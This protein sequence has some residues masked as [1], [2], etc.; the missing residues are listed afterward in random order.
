MEED[1][2]A[3]L[4][5]SL[6]YALLGA[7]PGDTPEVTKRKQDLLRDGLQA[8]ADWGFGGV[9]VRKTAKTNV[10][11]AVEK[12]WDKG[13][14][15]RERYDNPRSAK[16]REKKEQVLPMLYKVLY[17]TIEYSYMPQNVALNMAIGRAL[18][19]A[20]REGLQQDDPHLAKLYAVLRSV[21]TEAVD[22]IT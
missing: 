7:E 21:V 16:G 18:A 4:G 22:E 9:D 8:S 13:K 2:M 5:P 19:N 20:I 11:R 14:T 1:L 6:L 3:S 15:L 12:E 10:N 17:E